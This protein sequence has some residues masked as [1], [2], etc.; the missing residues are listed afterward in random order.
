MQKHAAKPPLP[1][2]SIRCGEGCGGRTIVL[3]KCSLPLRP[4]QWKFPP[5]NQA[6]P[7]QPTS[8]LRKARIKARSRISNQLTA[9]KLSQDKEK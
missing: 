2:A 3:E 7:T 6:N 1:G 4:V 9:T 5:I 8:P